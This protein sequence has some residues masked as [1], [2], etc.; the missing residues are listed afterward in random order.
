MKTQRHKDTEVQRHAVKKP[1]TRLRTSVSLCLCVYLERQARGKL[2]SAARSCAGHN[3]KIG[4]AAGEP[5][6]VEIGMVQQIVKFTTKFELVPLAQA[7][8]PFGSQIRC[9]QWS[10]A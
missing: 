7:K 10:A 9:E 8:R 4:G 1:Y 3:T 6:R 2:D 5:R